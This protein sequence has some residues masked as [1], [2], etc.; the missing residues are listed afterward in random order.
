MT[1]PPSWRGADL[2][3]RIA[4]LASEV[5]EVP[6]GSGTD[7]AEAGLEPS[8]AIRL[9]ACVYEE[10][11]LRLSVADIYTGRTPGRI[12]AGLCR[13]GA[14]GGAPAPGRH[15]PHVGA[16][17][18]RPAD[19]V[20]LAYTGTG[21]LGIDPGRLTTALKMVAA[22]QAA[23]RTPPGEA[24]NDA[25]RSAVLPDWDRLGV[26]VVPVPDAG[27][28][29]L[30]QARD[31]A[32][33][34]AL[35]GLD[36]VRGPLVRCALYTWN[37]GRLLAV[38]LHRSALDPWSLDAFERELESAYAAA[39]PS[40]PEDSGRAACAVHPS[41]GG[42]EP[43][44]AVADWQQRLAALPPIA[45]PAGAPD[46][47]EDGGAD[48]GEDRGDVVEWAVPVDDV[49][50]GRLR[51][52][53]RALGVSLTSLVLTAYARG[54]AE[55]TGQQ[56]FRVGLV[57]S[58][59]VEPWQEPT[60]G[61]RVLTLLVQVRGVPGESL[62]SLARRCDRELLFSVDHG[63]Y[64][65]TSAP[66]LQAT[67]CVEPGEPARGLRLGTSLLA[68]AHLPRSAPSTDLAAELLRADRPGGARQLMFTADPSRIGARGLRRLADAIR[69]ALME[70]AAE[71][72]AE[73]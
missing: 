59:R 48:G 45:W 26:D 61:R 12:A 14:G 32:A 50:L 11:G 66:L 47:D 5:L 18:G 70:L 9:A 4:E 30:Q 36:T 64:G 2:T 43:R 53:T 31:L 58:G 34:G 54:L 35:E 13:P 69:T 19:V 16:E 68:P 7:L 33:A 41:A 72:V 6:I 20:S 63:W 55:F 57:V 42:T 37:G 38:H 27:W 51:A 10:F 40:D 60:L 22:R 73:V 28:E 25:H 15:L 39:R 21:D 44:P 65:D 8:A 46:G 52:A 71:A 23:L 56:E 3:T 29:A 24:G 62:V 67:L 17:S 1:R 49:L